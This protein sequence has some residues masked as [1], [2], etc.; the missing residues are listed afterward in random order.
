MVRTVAAAGGADYDRQVSSMSFKRACAALLVCALPIVVA[1]CWKR[2]P[3]SPDASIRQGDSLMNERRFADAAIAYRAAVAGRPQD[4]AARAK[5]ADALLASGDWGQAAAEVLRSADLRRDDIELQVRAAALLASQGQ[6]I[7]AHDRAQAVLAASPAHVGALVVSANAAAE[8][9]FANSALLAFERSVQAGRLGD[10]DQRHERAMRVSAERDR[11]A[12]ASLRRALEL[13]PANGT[14]RLSMANLLFVTGRLAEA[15]ALLRLL[16]DASTPGTPW[17]YVPY[18]AAASAPRVLGEWYAY[19]SRWTDAEKYLRHAFDRGDVDAAIPLADV[20]MQAGRDRDAAVLLGQL[21]PQSDESG[22]VTLRL[23]R[24]DM[25]AGRIDSAL[26]RFDALLKRIPGSAPALV[27]KAEVKASQR[28]WADVMTLAREALTIDPS[29]ADARLLL[30]QALEATGSRQEAFEELR[31]GVR[32][33]PSHSLL[34]ERFA[35]IAVTMGR[36]DEAVAFAR[37]AVR[38]RPDDLSA[39]LVLARALAAA[40]DQRGAEQQLKRILN[41]SPDAV[42]ALTQLGVVQAAQ[43]NE[44]AARAALTRALQLQPDAWDAESE[45]IALELQEGRVAAARQLADGAAAAH[46]KD[47]RY[48][49][50]AANVARAEKDTSRTETLLRRVLSVDPRNSEAALSLARLLSD[51]GRRDEAISLLQNVSREVPTTE[52]RTGLAALLEDAGRLAEAQAAYESI[53]AG[54]ERA[55]AASVRLASMYLNRGN[56]PDKALELAMRIRDGF[57]DNGDANDLLGTIYIRKELPGQA[58]PFLQTAVRLSPGNPMYR[59]H[60]GQALQAVR[61]VNEARAQFSRALELDPTFP[62]ATEARG[63]LKRSPR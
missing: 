35:A 19:T 24:I 26:T 31:E 7:D 29:S 3:P 38:E 56:D 16:A 4:A 55:A 43:G 5:L 12:E 39:A 51:H 30:G 46:P 54:D 8:Q 25:R 28:A 50:A 27:A 15:E 14:A 34:A 63:A 9:P 52:V 41:K 10:I 23:G 58:I 49:L 47:A 20:Y 18:D 2:E 17:P 48:L 1:A 36:S 37:D 61:Q 6:F 33:N 44:A 32:R 53:V 62:H 45:L 11:N 42:P 59:F 60:L 21:P 22:D 40:G 57:P 13:D